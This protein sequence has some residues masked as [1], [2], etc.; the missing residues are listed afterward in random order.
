M[1]YV[2]SNLP[3]G[4]RLRVNYITRCRARSKREETLLPKWLTVAVI[5]D[6]KTNRQ[7]AVASASCGPHDNPNRKIGRAIAVGR[8][9]K[10]YH[11][12]VAA[13]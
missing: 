2:E 13:A 7:L 5:S 10:K 1:K 12:T 6:E 11:T 8:A 4:L 9:L 3:E